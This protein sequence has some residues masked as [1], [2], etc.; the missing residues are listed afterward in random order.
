[1]APPGLR[2]SNGNPAAPPYSN[3]PY[4][5]DQKLTHGTSGTPIAFTAATDKQIEVHTTNSAT[6]G[7]TSFEPFLFS[8]TLT[9]AGQVG[10]RV[11]AFMTTNVALG[12]WSNAFKAEVTY[13]A[14]GS[15]S[16]LGSALLAEMTLSAGTTSGNYAPL[17]IE[18]NVGSGASLGTK[19]TLQYMSVNGADA[20]T[21][22]TGGYIMNVQGLTVAS[23]KAFQVNTATA[24][25]HA[26]RILVGAT[27]YFIMLTDTGA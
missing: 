24:A 18:L 10:G 21:F 3:G 1:M 2:H 17:E 23:G 9:G 16:G 12:G 15:T 25:T 14:S 6:S 8:T 20:S 22:D 19:T 5:W 26:L 4:N 11:R 13:G 27:D 7:S